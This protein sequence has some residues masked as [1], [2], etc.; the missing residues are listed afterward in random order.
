LQR[1]L[2]H[3]SARPPTLVIDVTSILKE[4]V[5]AADEGISNVEKAKNYE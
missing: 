3:R 5:L 2:H 1:S 4:T